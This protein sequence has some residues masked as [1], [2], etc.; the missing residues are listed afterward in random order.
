[1]TCLSGK[2]EQCRVRTAV[3]ARRDKAFPRK[4]NVPLLF[5][6]NLNFH[7]AAINQFHPALAYL[8][9]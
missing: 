3:T 9:L 5:D 2:L 1:M 7:A 8:A 6:F 4:P